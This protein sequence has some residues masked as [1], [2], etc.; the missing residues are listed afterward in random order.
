[1]RG[2]KVNE[3]H[4]HKGRICSIE[5][6]S[7]ELV[8]NCNDCGVDPTCCMCGYCFNKEQHSDHNVVMH[9]S[10]GS[11]IC[12]C[13]DSASWKVP[14]KCPTDI[15]H[16]DSDLSD[17][18]DDFK[19]AIESTIRTALEYFL[20]VQAL[21]TQTVP[22]IHD[23]FA[24]SEDFTLFK[25][26]SDR[27]YLPESKYGPDKNADKYWLVVW[28]DEFHNWRSATSS[29]ADARKAY[30]EDYEDCTESASKID[31]FG[32]TLLL[33]SSDLST[34]QE[35][36]LQVQ[37]NGLTATI[38]SQRDVLREY[39]SISA[40]EW[41]SEILKNA[42]LMVADYAKHVLSELLLGKYSLEVPEVLPGNQLFDHEEALLR[43]NLM[44]DV[45]TSSV[46]P[47][48]SPKP[49]TMVFSKNENYNGEF[50]MNVR[51]YS[52]E[53]RSFTR[54]QLLF[55]L[56]MRFAKSTR[57]LIKGFLIPLIT[58]T[59]QSRLE[60]ARQIIEF[61]PEYEYLNQVEDREWALTLLE[62][63]RLQIY[64]D[65]HIGTI[66]LG[67]GRLFNVLRSTAQMFALHSVSLQHG[68]LIYQVP[69]EIN[70]RSERLSALEDQSLRGLEN[71]L[72]FLEPGS[73]KIFEL[74]HFVCLLEIISIFQN[75]HNITRKRGEHVDFEDRA[76]EI[77]YT[78]G[79]IAYDIT[80]DIGEL[81][82]GLHGRSA[83]VERAISV[84]S[85]YLSYWYESVPKKDRVIV[86]EMPV[87]F[88]RPLHSLFAELCLS[89]K[90]F[91]V[92]LLKEKAYS[93]T[94]PG[95]T[96]N[97]GEDSNSIRYV[98][99]ASVQSFVLSAQINS[100][101]WVRNGSSVI[102]QYW[103]NKSFFNTEGDIYIIQLAITLGQLS[104]SDIFD[105]WEFKDS[106]EGSLSFE[107]SVYEKD[108]A[109]QM[110]LAMASM[111]YHLITYTMPYDSSSKRGDPKYNRTKAIMSYCLCREPI[112]YSDMK[113]RF[114]DE[115][116]FEEVFEKIS[117]YT[118][119]RGINEYGKYTLKDE[120]YAELDPMDILNQYEAVDDI[121]DAL[122][123]NLARI[124]KV[125]I[126]DIVLKPQICKLSAVDLH[127]T[128]AISR[129]VKSPQFVKYL[130]KALRF[131]I[132]SKCD[133]HLMATLHLIHAIFEEDD[134][135]ASRS[136]EN[137]NGLKLFIDIPICNLLLYI[138][139]MEDMSNAT[140]KKASSIL[141][142]LL[143]KDDDVLQSLIDCFGQHHIDQYRKSKHGKKLETKSQR[144][145][146]IALKRQ[147]KVMA[148][149]RGQQQEFADTHHRFFDEMKKKE[150]EQA[151]VKR[152]FS[153][154]QSTNEEDG[155]I[156]MNDEEPRICVICRN[157]ENYDELFGIPALITESTAFWNIPVASRSTAPGCVIPEMFESYEKSDK[158]P[159]D[160][161][162]EP[163][164]ACKSLN[165]K[166]VV[167]GCPHGMHFSCFWNMLKSKSY[168]LTSFCCPLCQHY[169]NFFVPSLPSPNFKMNPTGDMIADSWEDIARE[170]EG[171]NCS[172]LATEVF[173][174]SM[175]R[176]LSDTNSAGFQK[177]KKQL[178]M[179]EKAD[180]LKKLKGG[181]SKLHGTPGTFCLPIVIAQLIASTLEMTEISQRNDDKADIHVPMLTKLLVRSFTQ[182]RVLL[183]Y[184]SVPSDDV[185]GFSRI[186]N[187][188]QYGLLQVV[189]SLYFCGNENFDT[190]FDFSLCRSAAKVIGSL[191]LRFFESPANLEF[192]SVLENAELEPGSPVMTGLKRL[193]RASTESLKLSD[194]SNFHL[195]QFANLVYRYIR[196]MYPR[197][198]AQVKLLA[199]CFNFANKDYTFLSM[200][201]LLM[202]ICGDEESMESKITRGLCGVNVWATPTII[203]PLE[204]P[205]RVH[206]QHLPSKV[207]EFLPECKKWEQIGGSGKM[208]KEIF[209]CL[210]CGKAVI[211][212]VQHLKEC[213]MTSRSYGVFFSPYRNVFEMEFS[214]LP[215]IVDFKSMTREYFSMKLRSPY[216]NRHGEP[217][218]GLFGAGDSGT[219][220]PKRYDYINKIWL[221]QSMVSSGL[222]KWAYFTSTPRGRMGT[223][224]GLDDA[225]FMEATFDAMEPNIAES[226][227]DE[228]I[229]ESD[230]ENSFTD[231][232]YDD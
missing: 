146:R 183:N 156:L 157:P 46:L 154:E 229:V 37:K 26:H 58:N 104:V 117:V 128:E 172:Q 53:Y 112:K 93:I 196:T 109:P 16:G 57:K 115:P 90:C 27:S 174:Q 86:S 87:S 149:M 99:D 41:I 71:V 3:D 148:K 65:P 167:S 223:I 52:A 170:T 193:I 161:R 199:E 207:S 145:H 221:N 231:G 47:S 30:G 103:I 107:E 45:Y 160:A 129:F 85:T 191:S 209:L 70:W 18:S 33:G 75:C 91:D 11:A 44:P 217:A 97:V 205:G 101:F 31:K 80:K 84:V 72:S 189:L 10:Q 151:K 173:D 105:R 25:V 163:K 35:P 122:L 43:D 54:L 110:L 66:L 228:F 98:A 225:G 195:E 83:D 219:L 139:E 131:A 220:D 96:L 123:K 120:L 206:L 56:E 95:N 158:P 6:P 185:L 55:F 150:G 152:K 232:D 5:I 22:K 194:Y 106:I 13:G 119:P 218:G 63:F 88:I 184:M 9:I 8:Y 111:F 178:Q 227:E 181:G 14:L 153:A 59:S 118:P 168:K 100:G 192:G 143:L 108:R 204:Y 36:Y 171:D 188:M 1:M 176:V 94:I 222:R 7:G 213:Q 68:R 201:E 61:L 42:N 17:L 197:Y 202:K 210:H 147:K 136:Q 51:S 132:D 69:T 179:L 190:L 226:D 64:H 208:T 81:V 142:M 2:Q 82:A 159:D 186:V 216:L 67:E 141:D 102:S 77:Y 200:D 114:G 23:F 130:Y 34:L 62:S 175:F 215:N 76:Y 224:F 79:R 212:K 180:F 198:E 164:S 121:Q 162:F 116:F 230:A 214:K 21:Q 155:D 12:D 15:S 113:F 19:N 134:I 89:Y 4:S 140:V 20:D 166:H 125:R 177:M 74:D 127:R 32:Y 48:S 92:N 203:P 29:L 28:N 49:Y 169:C 38:E 126:E 133:D 124:K 137:S 50:Y 211:R 39:L 144:A 182:Y 40:M 73:S 78:R 135:R 138:V 24:S 187:D 165:L 60:F